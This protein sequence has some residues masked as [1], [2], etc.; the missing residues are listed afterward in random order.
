MPVGLGLVERIFQRDQ[1][2]GLREG[3]VLGPPH[4][5]RHGVHTVEDRTAESVD[6]ILIGVDIVLAF[7]FLGPLF[8]LKLRLQGGAFSCCH[9]RDVHIFIKDMMDFFLVTI[10]FSS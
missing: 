2:V 4:P 9:F 7:L 8:G 1:R 6:G 5:V 3:Y 10:L